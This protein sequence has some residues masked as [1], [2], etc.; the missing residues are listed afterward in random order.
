MYIFFVISGI[1]SELFIIY[2]IYYFSV[3]HFIISS[4]IAPIA[5]FIESNINRKKE[6][7]Y[8]I[9]IS[10]I[11]F[12]IDIFAVLVYNEIIVLNICGIIKYTVK[13]IRDR[14]EDEH[15]QTEKIEKIIREEN[16]EKQRI[17][18]GSYYVDIG[19]NEYTDEDGK[20]ENEGI[21][22][23]MKITNN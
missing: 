4:F 8:V 2:T 15:S 19:V 5:V 20:D 21:N 17:D 1:I 23:E 7:D 14:A 13:G 6:E 22:Y 9:I 11:V 16:I 3:T 12:I 18:I 10:I